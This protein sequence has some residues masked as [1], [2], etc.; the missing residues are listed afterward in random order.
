MTVFKI[1]IILPLA[2]WLWLAGTTRK[3]ENTKKATPSGVQHWTL[4]STPA[5]VTNIIRTPAS[6]YIYIYMLPIWATNMSYRYRNYILGPWAKRLKGTDFTS[7]KVPAQTL[8]QP[9]CALTSRDRQKIKRERKTSFSGKARPVTPPN[10]PWVFRGSSL[11]TS[12]STSAAFFPVF[13]LV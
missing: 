13:S 6:G 3:T 4:T 8:G 7:S 1:N 5:S 9:G 11:S 2:D 12:N 10:I